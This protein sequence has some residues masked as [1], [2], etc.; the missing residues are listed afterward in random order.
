MPPSSPLSSPPLMLQ[1]HCSH[2]GCTEHTSALCSSTIITTI[3]VT[4]TVTTTTT[5]S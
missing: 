4:I 2:A 3:T 5:N 1:G